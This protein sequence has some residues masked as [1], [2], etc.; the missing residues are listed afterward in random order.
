MKLYGF[1]N[2]NR[3]LRALPQSV[4]RDA[5]GQATDVGARLLREAARAKAP[6]GKT[7]RLQRGIGSERTTTEKARAVS[8]VGVRSDVF[9]GH[10]VEYGTAQ[11]HTSNIGA[12]GTRLRRGSRARPAHYRN[13]FRGSMPAKPFMRPA[14]DGNKEGLVQAMGDVLKRRI[15]RA[16]G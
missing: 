2:L 6:R 13:K 5:L 16:A 4:Q 8:S 9:Y 12:P 3:K 1:D 14:W 15:E 7:R 11:R 10:L